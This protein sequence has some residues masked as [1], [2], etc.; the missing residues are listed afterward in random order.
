MQG[1]SDLYYKLVDPLAPMSLT[2][3]LW[4][5]GESNVPQNWKPTNKSWPVRVVE[6]E[7]NKTQISVLAENVLED[8]DGMLRHPLD[9]TGFGA[10]RQYPLGK[11][12]VLPSLF[13]LT[14]AQY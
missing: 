3:A 10:P 7:K 5:Q 9:L 4:Y 13:I 2:G 12:A 6:G 11:L 14:C 8:A 1:N